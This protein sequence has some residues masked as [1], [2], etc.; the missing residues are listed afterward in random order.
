M[1][2]L[3]DASRRSVVLAA[4]VSLAL[5][6][7]V[8]QALTDDQSLP[9]PAIDQNTDDELKEIVVTGSRIARPD[10]ERLQPT[11]V[12]TSE[13]LDRRAYTNVIDA[14]NELPGFGQ[15]DN[16]L[17]GSQASQGVGQ[18]FANFLGL[19]SQRTLT[20]VDGRRFVPANTPSP[21][22]PTGSGG[23][24]VDLNVIPTQLIDRIETI[25]V[26]GAPIYG[27][28][29]IAGTVN[30]ILKHDYE[31]LDVDAQG[32]MSSRGDASQWRL[33]ALTGKNFDD[34]RGN[35]TL[36]V[37]IANTDGL[38]GTQRPRYAEDLGF[39]EP[40]S[41]SPYQYV[42]AQH[43][44]FGGITTSGV[45]MV[46]DGYLG[47]NPNFAI[48]NSAGQPLAFNN[49]QLAPYNLGTFDAS[50][51]NSIGGQGV[52]GAQ[53][54]TLLS[55]QERINATSLGSFKINDNARLFGELWYSETHT[56]YPV[57][58]GVYD[59]YLSNVAGQVGGNL[60]IQAN[61]PFLSAADQATIAKDLAAYAAASPTNPQQTSQF[62]LA[63]LNQDI[64]NGGTTANQN[65]KRIVVGVDGTLPIPSGDWKYEISGNYGESSNFSMTPS[66]NWQNLQ[67]ALNAVV[68]PGG[69]I[70]CAPGYTNS[71]APTESSTCAPFNPFGNGIA[72]GAAL[73]YVT[74]LA[75]EQSILTQRDFNASV[76]GALFSLPAGAVKVALGYEN[77][78]ETSDYT[79]SAFFE[80]A[81]GYSVP[82]APLSGSFMTNEVFGELLVPLIS[83]AQAVPIVHRLEFEG[84]AREVDHSVAGKATT[85]TAGLRFE[86]VSVL[87]L[88]G[89]YTRAIRA[90]SVTEAFLPTTQAYN[91]ASD[92]C[93]KTLINSGPDPAVRA[94]N[95]AKAGITQPFSSNILNFS[96]P[97]LVTGDPNLQNEVA[98]SRTFGFVLRPS[99]RTS[100]AVD[101]VKIDI[102]QAIVSLTPTNV[103]DACYD[104]PSYP[105]AYCSKI[106][107][108]STGQVTLVQTPYANAGFY[109]FNGIQTEFDW[110]FDVPF[111]ST[112]GALGSVDVRLNE[113]FTNQLVQQVGSE[114]VVP[115]AGQI[116]NSKHRGVV[117]VTWHKNQLY[118]LWQARFIGH[119]VWDNT[120]PANNSAVQ[121]V[122]NWWVHNLTVGYSVD[123]NLKLQLVID[124][125]FDKEAPYPLPAVP[126]NSTAYSSV[127]SYFSGVLGRY[128]VAQ[129]SYKF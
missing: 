11:T 52:S 35:I 68:G 48:T 29:A 30:I 38:A 2:D 8:A 85:W 89:N 100:L 31:G 117:D 1:I 16:S 88:R 25:A 9:K 99:A 114:D 54:T 18:S 103:L 26:G 97:I 82:L 111:A 95:C 39:V 76:N 17:V 36:N 79:P 70:I 118:A 119:A 90:P 32:G 42:L 129:A 72:S 55:P 59:T 91:F 98:D 126:P 128:F 6:G 121:G 64:Q 116:G 102:S 67:N 15:P 21:F 23:E 87:Q 96:A 125:V 94:A 81:A 120:L 112:P 65:T 80:Q 4:L 127:E 27:S 34:G 104:S 123:S 46:D 22:G 51:V 108:N 86:P 50:G 12:L 40:T 84:A 41:A 19:G 101:Y 62:Y 92:P 110:S 113:F 58:Q 10:V 109:N 63:R 13:F 47:F 3:R 115:L 77:R 106:T 24:Q 45:P 53:T 83:P 105:N 124:N 69:K 107:R 93:D 14:L 7:A 122:G 61:N 71:P 75:T 49:G 43:V 44:V 33:R 37:E 28:D 74:S 73:A 60:I 78:R 66:A 56:A 5:G 20:L 57:A